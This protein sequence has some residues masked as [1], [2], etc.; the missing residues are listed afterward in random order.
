MKT[1]ILGWAMWLS[2]PYMS[3]QTL[4][5]L[6]AGEAG[7]TDHGA[8][9]LVDSFMRHWHITGGAVA[10]SRDGHTIFSE[11]FG[12]ADAAR[13]IPA[14]ADNLFRIA[15]VSKPVTSIAIM[16]LVEQ[17][18][19]S[20]TD[21]VFGEGRL[22]SDPYYLDVIRDKR[23]Y[24]IT[25]QNLLEHTAGW[26]RKKPLDGYT[27]SDPVFFPVYVARTEKE[28]Y[29][30]GDSTLI[31]FSLRKGLH[32]RPGSRF[33]YSNVGYLILGKVIE[34][35]SGQSYERY[36][37]S[38]LLHPISVYDMQLGSN[39]K[40]D[41]KPGEVEY[42]SAYKTLSAYGNRR[43]VPWQ[44]GGFNLEAM[45][46]H[47]GWIATA[48]DLV[49]IMESAGGRSHVQLLAPG[50][51]STMTRPSQRHMSYAKGWQTDGDEIWHTGSL[52]GTA[53]IMGRTSD[54]YAWA[55][56]FN[57]RGD[58]STKFWNA[59]HRLPRIC[60]EKIEEETLALL[61]SAVSAV[62]LDKEPVFI[63]DVGYGRDPLDQGYSKEADL[64]AIVDAIRRR[65]LYLRF[66]A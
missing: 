49:R 4:Q 12:F 21:T 50:T 1:R 45:N 25:V 55:L 8:A 6:P 22:I 48:G 59:L 33:G 37:R 35:V 53:A 56:L 66:S 10:I 27:H 31:R 51:I 36:V 16:K 41:R 32:F 15:S 54:G 58:N 60:I 61:S 46:A 19:L 5:R 9:G 2:T 39:L 20:L 38:N 18:R 34:K 14:R 23:I 17:G 30:A 64:V 62:K 28:P 42:V 63:K 43:P 44:Y 29:P 40:Q 65:R 26:D 13:T 57:G 52:D 47:G 3:A 11:G 24:S 7:L